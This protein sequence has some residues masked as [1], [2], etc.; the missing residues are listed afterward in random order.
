MCL[1]MKTS[2]SAESSFKS[3]GLTSAHQMIDITTNIRFSV[4][5]TSSASPE[6][7]FPILS[8]EGIE[9]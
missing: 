4:E 7:L 6:P 8:D 3:A 2:S 5:N 9:V 1:I